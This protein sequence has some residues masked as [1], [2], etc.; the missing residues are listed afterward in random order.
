MVEKLDSL[1]WSR[2]EKKQIAGFLSL[3]TMKTAGTD[4]CNLGGFLSAAHD[5]NLRRK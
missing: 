3:L 1:V 5:G 4:F 2:F